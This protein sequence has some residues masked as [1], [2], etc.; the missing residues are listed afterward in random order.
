MPSQRRSKLWLISTRALSLSQWLCNAFARIT[1]PSAATTWFV[2]S[3]LGIQRFANVADACIA[4]PLCDACCSKEWTKTVIPPSVVSNVISFNALLHVKFCKADHADS[5]TRILSK[6][7][8]IAPSMQS[9]PPSSETACSFSASSAIFS[10]AWHAAICIRAFS[11]WSSIAEMIESSPP[12]LAMSD[13][14]EWSKKQS[15]VIC[16]R[17]RSTTASSFDL[18]SRLNKSRSGLGL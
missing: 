17:A 8:I 5:C 15:I 10:S 9:I 6:W 11:G 3:S 18:K 16:W 12:D 7:L 13:L 1:I 2:R 4:T 14:A